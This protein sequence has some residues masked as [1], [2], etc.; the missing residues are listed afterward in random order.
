MKISGLQEETLLI[1]SLVDK[2]TIRDL[3]SVI[4]KTQ[5]YKYNK[6]EYLEFCIR[7]S[8]KSLVDNGFLKVLIAKYLT[9]TLTPEGLGYVKK[10]ECTRI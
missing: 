9:Y 7:R 10:M 1:L 6:D 3:F 8:C 2:A 4:K 5:G